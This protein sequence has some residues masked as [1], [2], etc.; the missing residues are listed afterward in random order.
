[1]ELDAAQQKQITD[2][3]HKIMEQTKYNAQNVIIFRPRNI[4]DVNYVRFARGSGCQSAVGQI[5]GE[6][7]NN[8]PI[9]HYRKKL[10]IMK[11]QTSLNCE[12]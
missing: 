2:T 9:K 1:M 7:V 11:N 12:S 5:R 3:M 4:R 6:Q 10:K 8:F